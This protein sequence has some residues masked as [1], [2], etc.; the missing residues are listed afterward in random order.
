[1]KGPEPDGRPER[2]MPRMDLDAL[3][4]A[5]VLAPRTFAR[6][7]FF[8][9]YEDAAA[10]RVRRRASRV[11]GI[12]RQLVGDGR[13]RG[14]IVGEQVLDDGQVLLRYRVGELSFARTTALSAVEAA[15]LRY[16][17][18]RA[19]AGPLFEEDR[20]LVEKTLGKLGAE[21]ELAR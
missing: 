20:R 9:L 16:A 3:F 17:L 12:I 6:N 21:L 15:A 13:P 8:T 2:A 5:L 11:R 7:R 18:H 4:C 1:V 19:G 14:E 10:R